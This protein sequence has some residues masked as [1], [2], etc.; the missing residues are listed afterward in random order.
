[1]N[2]DHLTTVQAM[3]KGDRV[4]LTS[5]QI[6]A[7][8][9]GFDIGLDSCA[10][11]EGGPGLSMCWIGRAGRSDARKRVNEIIAEDTAVEPKTE[12]VGP[13][14]TATEVLE[15]RDKYA[16]LKSPE[17]AS[18][19]VEPVLENAKA[20]IETLRLKLDTKWLAIL[21]DQARHIIGAHSLPDSPALDCWFIEVGKI[22]D[23]AG[24]S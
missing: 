3:L 12:T 13:M 17:V 15:R 2:V 1:M 18:G 7:I 14:M 19:I 5:E 16:K 8:T 23:K 22:L 21:L 10:H 4:V 9:T 11:P 24:D 6:N 20:E